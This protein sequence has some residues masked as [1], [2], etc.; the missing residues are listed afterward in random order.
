M[1]GTRIFFA[2]SS[3]ACLML[4]FY[5]GSN[6]EGWIYFNDDEKVKE[7]IYHNAIEGVVAAAPARDGPALRES[8]LNMRPDFFRSKEYDCVRFMPKYGQY[9]FVRVF[10]RNRADG[11]VNISNY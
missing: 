3:A 1:K 5:L 6:L 9:G 11:T 10:C 7:S 4:G 2:L 8:L